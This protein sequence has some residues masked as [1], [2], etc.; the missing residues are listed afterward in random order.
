MNQLFK[1]K[2]TLA[3]LT[4]G[5]KG[6]GTLSPDE[7]YI[8]AGYY[9]II[10]TPPIYNPTLQT[11]TGELVLDLN[12]QAWSRVYTI[13]DKPLS[14]LADTRIREVVKLHTQHLYTDMEVLFPSGLATIQFR[15]D[16]DRMN[17]SNQA[18]GAMA[19]IISGLP[20][21]VMKYRT[22]DNIWQ[23]ITA[24]QMLQ[25]AMEVLTT[26]QVIKETETFH[27]DALKVM[28]DPIL[29]P[30]TT[31]ADIVNYDVTTQWEG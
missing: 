4:R 14:V 21:T 13:T 29:S 15:N 10:I 25:L 18:S 8:N 22:L 12:A 23:E 5:T 24:A 28:A 2:D 7:S 16:T 31:P 20:D 6:F 1:H 30:A 17:L 26:K 3:I 11:Y 9:P 19:H 27:K